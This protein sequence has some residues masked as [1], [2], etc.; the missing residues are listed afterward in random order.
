MIDIIIP[1]YEAHNFLPTALES[2]KKQTIKN[3]IQVTIVDDGSIKDYNYIIKDFQTF[4]LIKII[5]LKKNHGPGFAKQIGITKTSNLYLIF[6]DSD[7]IFSSRTALE[8]LYNKALTNPN[9]KL[10]AG[11]EIKNKKTYFHETHMVGKLFKREIII[12]YKIK[13]PNF[14]MEEDTAFTLCY[15]SILNENEKAQINEIVY[16]Y[17]NVNSSSITNVYSLKN[18][19]DLK[20]YFKA[21]NYS[22]KYML[23]H[24]SYTYL[25]KSLIVILDTLSII[26]FNYYHD[27]EVDYRER[28]I[29]NCFKFYQKYKHYID[30][31][32]YINKKTIS[33]EDYP[34]IEA[35]YKIMKSYNR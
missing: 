21:I 22:Y 5:K 28:F 32:Y 10:I 2:I 16:E 30:K 25:K 4:F 26:Y 29:Q 33:V 6:L 13:V 20:H 12:K 14:R 35:F 34:R 18:N 31:I 24:Q 8:S 9:L 3:K 19:Y 27:C 15:N 7:D 17:K 23:K 11:K 1:A